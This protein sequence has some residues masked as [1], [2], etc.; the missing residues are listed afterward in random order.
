[1]TKVIRPSD[2]PRFRNNRDIIPHGTWPRAMGID[3]VSAY[4]DISPATIR[5]KVRAGAL[6]A[7]HYSNPPRWDRVQLDKWLDEAGGTAAE[8]TERTRIL[9]SKLAHAHTP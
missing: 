9:L 2:L 1:M 4:L 5:A 7:A 6:P 8:S 3:L